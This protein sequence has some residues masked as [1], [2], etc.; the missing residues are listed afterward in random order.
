MDW[1]FFRK[2]EKLIELQVDSDPLFSYFPRE[3]WRRLLS[4]RF[5]GHSKFTVT[6]SEYAEILKQKEETERFHFLINETARLNNI[7][8]ELEKQGEI[9]TAISVYEENI[10]LGYP[11]THSYDRLMILYRKQR[12][13]KNERRIIHAALDKF[14]AENMRRAEKAKETHPELSEEIDKACL[15]ISQVWGDDGWIIFNPHKLDK[16]HQRLIKIQNK[17]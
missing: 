10:A 14:S 13:Y 6:E 8:A 3:I 16:W 5:S 11:A 17:I 12:D 2:R 15:T 1:Y 7:G 9:D 4:S